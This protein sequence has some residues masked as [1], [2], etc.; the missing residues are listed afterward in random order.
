MGLRGRKDCERS[1]G[2]A[3]V[4]PA[5]AVGWDMLVVPGAEAEEIAELVM[6]AAEALGGGEAL[7]L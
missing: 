2:T 3:E 5:T 1:G 6:A 4:K 7:E